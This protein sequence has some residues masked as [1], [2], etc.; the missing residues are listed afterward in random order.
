ME[1]Q[2]PLF[3]GF[4]EEEVASLLGCLG[5]VERQ[6]RKGETILSEGEPAAYLGV[7]RRGMALIGCDDVWGNHTV[8]GS[9]PPGAVF[10]EAY[11]CLPGEPLIITVTAAEDTAVLLLPVARVLMPCV[12]ACALHTRLLR[13]LLAVSA[14]R[15]LALSRRILHTSAKSIRGRLCSYFSECAKRQGS[16]TITVPYSRQLLA[17]YLGVDRSALSNELSKMQREGLIRYHRNTFELENLP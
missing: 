7:V 14:Q 2:S 6:Y 1:E 3:V 8:L 9:A 16:G 10:A 15:S 13:N 12:N 11:A 5:A 17:D 4:T